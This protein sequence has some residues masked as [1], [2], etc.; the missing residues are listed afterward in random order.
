MQKSIWIF[1]ILA[2]VL[3][4]LLEF[5]F[6]KS[7]TSTAA[8]LYVTKL[9]VLVICVSAGLVLTRKLLDG[10]ISIARTLL[11]GLL[12]S[13]VRAVVMIVFFLVL[14][15]PNGKFYQPKIDAA[16]LLAADKVQN[17]DKIKPA[18]KPMELEQNEIQIKRQYEPIGYSLLCIGASLISGF[19]ISI[20]VGAF[21]STNMMYEESQSIIS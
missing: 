19:I 2:G 4:G 16:L 15:A 10:T 18:D 9:A 21:I 11:T 20:L 17:D 3:C 12:I 6:F 1:G 7:T 5:L 14:Y 13:L 8:A